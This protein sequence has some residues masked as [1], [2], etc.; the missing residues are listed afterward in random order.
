MEIFGHRGA[1]GH[2]PENT[3]AAFRLA[4]AQ[5][6]DGVELDVHLSRDARVMVH[7]DP[8]T[9]RSA[10]QALAIAATASRRLREL[11]LWGGGPM[12]Y[13]EEVLALLP[14]GKGM[15][16]E[17]KCGPEIVPALGAALAQAPAGA[18]PAVISF[19]LEVLTACRAALSHIP[20]YLVVDR[21]R[22]S[23]GAPCPYPDAL[24]E[25]ALREG[26]AGLDPDYRGI[27]PGFAGRVRGAGLGLLC[28]TV[29]DPAA[30]RRLAGLGV[31]GIA[32]D[33]PAEMRA[34]LPTS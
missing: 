10:G 19:H 18:L 28:W 6:A 17:V 27:D 3:L 1:S 34:A 2:A 26:L 20:C 15:L 24:I 5:G 9:R 31:T 25:L 4:F 14:P 33:Y 8:D 13:L 32:S 30:A 12:P 22:D 29:N 16:I 23:S 7:H 21:A 11:P